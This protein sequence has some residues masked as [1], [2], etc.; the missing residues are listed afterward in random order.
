MR[1][2]LVAL[3]VGVA[4]CAPAASRAAPAVATSAAVS[5]ASGSG[6]QLFA[7]QGA[8]LAPLPNGGRVA[9]GNGWIEPRFA[10]FPPGPR[11]DLDIVVVS[12]ATNLP[13]VA[14]VAVVAEM[15]DMAHGAVAQ[16]A[17]PAMTGHH[18][19]K[20]DLAMRGT[21]RFTVNVEL[22]GV[23]SATVLL[24]AESAP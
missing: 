7:L 1:M 9:I 12:A 22:E 16:R 15:L 21:W 23:R 14:T 20:L 19:A 13:A 5:E 24:L 6:A 11:S 8:F 3:C 2:L 17:T 4:G 18:V 10:P